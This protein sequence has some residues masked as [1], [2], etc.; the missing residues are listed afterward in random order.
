MESSLFLLILSCA[1]GFTAIIWFL[2]VNVKA[3]RMTMPYF[4]L[5]ERNGSCY[6]NEG[7]W[8]DTFRLVC[9]PIAQWIEHAPSKRVAAGSNPVGR[10]DARNQ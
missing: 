8:G 9:A 4:C 3:G 5:T 10:A 2:G 1:L 7:N 6:D